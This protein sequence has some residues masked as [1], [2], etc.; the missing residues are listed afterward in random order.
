MEA[1]GNIGKALYDAGLPSTEF[2]AVLE[3]FLKA[4]DP[5]ERDVAHGIVVTA[6]RDREKEWQ[7]LIAKALDENWRRRRF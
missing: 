7:G 1:A 5:S 3:F 2:N 4:E 6:S